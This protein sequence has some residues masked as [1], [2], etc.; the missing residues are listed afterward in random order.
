MVNSLQETACERTRNPL[1]CGPVGAFLS[2]LLNLCNPRDE[3]FNLGGDKKMSF[4]FIGCLT[5]YLSVIAKGQAWALGNR[6]LMWLGILQLIVFAEEI[7]K[8]MTYRN[9]FCIGLF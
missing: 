4:R 1:V 5:A 9:W 8:V 2:V 7:N 6:V 3:E